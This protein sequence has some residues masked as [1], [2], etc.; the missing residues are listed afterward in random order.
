MDQ[1]QQKFY[2][3][4]SWAEAR[5]SF[6]QLAKYRRI[7]DLD[8]GTWRIYF[9]HS[10]QPNAS[11]P[12]PTSIPTYRHA[13]HHP[14]P[15]F[16]YI[17]PTHQPS[18]LNAFMTDWAALTCLPACLFLQ[19]LL[20][21]HL[22]QLDWAQACEPL[23]GGQGPLWHLSPALVLRTRQQHLRWHDQTANSVIP[24]LRGTG[25]LVSVWW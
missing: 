7:E 3:K 8:S 5:M 18:I 23:G 12:S 9:H 21:S 19:L 16:W 24:E 25:S 22:S 4:N 2:I 6:P 17:K 20:C 13:L 11:H 15:S 10:V 14:T 1:G